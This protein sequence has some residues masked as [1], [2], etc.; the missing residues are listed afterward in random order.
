MSTLKVK[1]PFMLEAFTVEKTMKINKFQQ[2]APSDL[3]N[4]TPQ[5]PTPAN[6]SHYSVITPPGS[7]VPPST[8][9]LHQFC[10]PDSLDL[11][12]ALSNHRHYDSSV[13]SSA[14]MSVAE[15]QSLSLAARPNLMA[16]T[17]SRTGRELQRWTSVHGSETPNCR[18]T[19]GCVP[20]MRDGR[21]LLVSSSKSPNIFSFPKGGWEQDESLPLSALRETLEEAGVTGVLGPPLETLI[22]ETKK[23]AKRRQAPQELVESSSATDSDCSINNNNNNKDRPTATSTTIDISK[24]ASSDKG[25]KVHT[26]NCMTLFPLYVQ[27]VYDHWPEETRVRRVVT[28]EEAISLLVHRPEFAKALQM[29][30]DRNLHVLSDGN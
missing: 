11:V 22:F 1:S 30:A 5:H 20:I 9:E 13:A 21:I 15:L 17:M 7:I 14:D 26:H 18:L 3:D 24:H 12:P 10:F 23:A 27:A 2:P 6:P 28:I 19:T 29:V 25:N 8:S 4:L 16:L